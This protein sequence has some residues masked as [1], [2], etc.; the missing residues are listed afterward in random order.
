MVQFDRFIEFHSEGRRLM[1]EMDRTGR[2]CVHAL[3]GVMAN[4]KLM[5]DTIAVALHYPGVLSPMEQDEDWNS[6]WGRRGDPDGVQFCIQQWL[7]LFNATEATLAADF[8]K[9]Q[10]R[11]TLMKMEGAQ[12]LLQEINAFMDAFEL[13]G[14]AV[15]SL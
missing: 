1:A 8:R 13:F 6:F 2:R 5:M 10:F 4:F 15:L 12:A 14:R 3:R 7:A 11:A 9:R